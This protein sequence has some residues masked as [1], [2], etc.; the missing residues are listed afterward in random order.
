M[1]KEDK[2]ILTINQNAIPTFKFAFK[3]RERKLILQK[4]ESVT[5]RAHL[6]NLPRS[7]SIKKGKYNVK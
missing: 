5:Q 6:T 4:I 2:E 7:Q 3:A 1:N